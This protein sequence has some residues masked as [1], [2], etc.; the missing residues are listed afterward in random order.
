MSAGELTITAAAGTDGTRTGAPV[1]EPHPAGSAS[2]QAT[3]YRRALSTGKGP[4]FLRRA[5]GWM[6][7]LDI[8]RWCAEP[9][10]ADRAVLAKSEG[11]VLDI[12]CGP[13]R[14]VGA[15]ARAGHGVLG[16]DVSPTAVERTTRG[17]GAA[18]VRSVFEP[19]PGEGRWDTALLLDGNIGIGGDP[20][21]LLARVA[22]VIAPRG[23]LVVEAA[24]ADVDERVR[25]RVD[26]GHHPAPGSGEFFAWARLGTPALV[27][28]AERSGW[29][30]RDTWGR[31]GRS[32]VE[33]RR[34]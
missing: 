19:L 20:D 15:L 8:E 22:E 2:W 4:L 34:T 18:L 16:I 30:V 13:G 17:G 14:I 26:D 28:Q 11:T 12:G 27:R 31:A 24:E 33:L 7:P 21:V 5:D 29:S 3:A 9:D 32:F 10:A 6:L 25:V 23:L 1:G